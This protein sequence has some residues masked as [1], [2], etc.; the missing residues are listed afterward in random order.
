VSRHIS[1]TDREDQC[2]IHFQTNPIL[3]FHCASALAD[4]KSDV[5]NYASSYSDSRTDEQKLA[6]VV[7][8]AKIQFKS[9]C[10][11]F[12][13]VVSSGSTEIAVCHYT[14]EP[15]PFCYVLERH[16]NAS[17][18][19]LSVHTTAPWNSPIVSDKNAKLESYGT[20]DVIDAT[21]FIDTIPVSVVLIST[22]PL[23]QSSADATIFTSKFE[24]A[25]ASYDPHSALKSQWFC[26]PIEMFTL[27]G[28]APVEYIT[29]VYHSSSPLKAFPPLAETFGEI[30]TLWL[31]SWKRVLFGDFF[32]FE[33]SDIPQP[34]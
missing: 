9:W 21:G 14:G 28:L 25:N 4:I 8:T 16:I 15:R 34:V 6:R 22:I 10:S 19:N 20:F 13:E 23:L 29:K 33:Q 27:F 12:R 30:Q 31:F 5:N 32:A 18:T 11:T 2:S 1:V 17:P 3:A 24:S 7:K 26:D